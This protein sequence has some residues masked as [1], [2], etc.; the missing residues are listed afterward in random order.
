M[1][2]AGGR[3]NTT[4][5]TDVAGCTRIQIHTLTHNRYACIDIYHWRKACRTRQKSCAQLY[6]YIHRLIHITGERQD[7]HG[8]RRGCCCLY[9]YIQI[10]KHTK[11]RQIYKFTNIYHRREAGRTR[12]KTRMFPFSSCSSLKHFLRAA[13]TYI[14]AMSIQIH[15]HIW[16]DKKS[17]VYSIYELYVYIVYITSDSCSSSKRFFRA[18]NAY[19][20]QHINGT[21][22]RDS[23]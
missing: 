7:G 19:I 3:A 4:E 21:Q 22:S 9:S 23:F 12:Q 13:N 5:D 18:A 2:T 10:H 20:K 6:K 11:N 17:H 1:S 16:A 8:R 15:V 14:Y